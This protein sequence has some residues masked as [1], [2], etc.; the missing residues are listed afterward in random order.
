M[1][2]YIIN[3]H[4]FGLSVVCLDPESL[5]HFISKL[6]YYKHNIK[7]DKN[8]LLRTTDLSPIIRIIEEGMPRD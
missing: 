1:N 3:T 5:K 8:I 6:S 7:E 4:N 2:A